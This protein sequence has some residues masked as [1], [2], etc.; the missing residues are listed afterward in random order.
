MSG[1][2]ASESTQIIDPFGDGPTCQR[3]IEYLLK[4]RVNVVRAYAIDP[5]VDHSECMQALADAGI[6][7]I[8]DLGGT[9]TEVITRGVGLWNYQLYDRFTSVVDAFHNYTNVLGFFAGNEVVNGSDGSGSAAFVKAATRDV[10]AYM[11]K[12]NYR[13]IPVGYSAGDY[14]DIRVAT[15]D[16]LNCGDQDNAIDML[17]LNLYSWCGDA[18][19]TM[20]GYDQRIAEMKN[21]SIPV[22]L[23]E[24]GCTQPSPRNFTEVQ[25]I[26]GSKMTSVFSGGIVYQYY[27]DDAEDYGTGCDVPVLMIYQL[28]GREQVSLPFSGILSLHPPTTRTFPSRWLP[29]VLHRLLS[30]LTVRQ[31]LL[32]DV[33][34]QGHRGLHRQRFHQF[35]TPAFALV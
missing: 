2:F 20:S 23:S 22:F 35:P 18:S 28:I 3:D 11:R 14:E 9:K 12:K 30:S 31:T 17:G 10:K 15:A 27:V 25:A 1:H 6:Y 7:I 24:Y 4:L 26:Y 33:P 21:Y 5:T 29:Q 32:K 34:R 19:L 13:A 8:A 16:Y